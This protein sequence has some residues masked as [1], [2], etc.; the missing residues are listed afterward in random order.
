MSQPT[1]ANNESGIGVKEILGFLKSNKRFILTITLCIAAL[2]AA[3]SVLAKN[4]FETRFLV[5]M[6]QYSQS[7]V[8]IE[9]PAALGERLRYPAAYS[10]ATFKACGMEG[11]SQTQGSLGGRLKAGLVRTMPSVLEITIRTTSAELSLQCAQSVFEMIRVHQQELVSE[12]LK[13]SAVKL[14]S[15]RKEYEVELQDLEQIKKTGAVHF[16]YLSKQDR[17]SWL[18]SQIDVLEGDILIAQQNPAKLVLPMMSLDDPVA[19]NRGLILIVGVLSGLLL[20][21][22]GAIIRVLWKKYSV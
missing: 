1:Q 3:Y 14:A 12:K 17:I 21:V 5:Q 22:L 11:S 8:S 19:P 6:A 13:G 15:Y 16:A 9:S 20:G 10:N 4:K 18:R 2:A 7:A